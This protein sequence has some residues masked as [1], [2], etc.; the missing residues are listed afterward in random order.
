MCI[1]RGSILKHDLPIVQAISTYSLD[2]PPWKSVLTMRSPMAVRLVFLDNFRPY[3]AV[4]LHSVACRCSPTSGAVG[5][6]G[7]TARDLPARE[8]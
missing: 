6:S 4:L 8:H 1:V 7:T 5:R 3:E 2:R